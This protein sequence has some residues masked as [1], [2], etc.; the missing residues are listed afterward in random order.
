[1]AGQPCQPAEHLERPD[2]EVGAFPP[3]G[4][5]QAIDLVLHAYSS[6]SYLDIKITADG[7]GGQA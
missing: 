5:D 1:M 6:G 7:R 3:P 4:G 2:I